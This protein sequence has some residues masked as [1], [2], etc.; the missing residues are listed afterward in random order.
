MYLFW[1]LAHLNFENTK[2]NIYIKSVHHKNWALHNF[3]LSNFPV[4]FSW[5][6]PEISRKTTK[7]SIM[8]N[9]WKTLNTLH[10]PGLEWLRLGW[11]WQYWDW[12]WPPC[13]QEG[14][15]W[16]WRWCSR[17]SPCASSP[18]RPPRTGE[19]RQSRPPAP[20]TP[21]SPCWVSGCWQKSRC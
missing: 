7:K 8:Q 3:R 2:R 5:G 4:L 20:A 13:R 18:S 12:P 6:W 19:C 21:P 16:G 15:A 14:R 10:W 11:S 17:G 9:I 1:S